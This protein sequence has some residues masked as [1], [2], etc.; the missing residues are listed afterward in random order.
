MY[1]DGFKKTKLKC[2]A[3]YVVNDMNLLIMW[4]S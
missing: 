2:K 3:I 4:V 1:I